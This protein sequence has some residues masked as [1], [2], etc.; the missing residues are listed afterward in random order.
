MKMGNRGN[1]AEKTRQILNKSID[2]LHKLSKKKTSSKLAKQEISTLLSNHFLSSNS[3]SEGI[4][5]DQK[6]KFQCYLDEAYGIVDKI[7]NG[8]APLY[9]GIM[10]MNKVIVKNQSEKA[11]DEKSVRK[12]L[13]FDSLENNSFQ[14]GEDSASEEDDFKEE[15]HEMLSDQFDRSGKQ[16]EEELVKPVRMS[17]KPD[18]NSEEIAPIQ[19]QQMGVNE[20]MQEVL[21]N[22]EILEKSIL[23]LNKT[24]HEVGFEL[25]PFDSK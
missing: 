5:T 8:Q 24:L 4:D 21:K 1:M 3:Q 22:K 23:K 2:L 17:L 7:D 6:V 11:K 18:E 15:D 25:R 10:L 9:E 12:S 19:S 13:H 14:E 16:V 20:L